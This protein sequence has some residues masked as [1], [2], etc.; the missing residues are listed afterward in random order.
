[1]HYADFLKEQGNL[2]TIITEEE[3]PF[4]R[5]FALRE[6]PILL[7]DLNQFFEDQEKQYEIQIEKFEKDILAWK[8][9][10]DHVRAKN[11]RP[12]DPSPRFDIINGANV[13]SVD[14]LSDRK[15]LFLTIETPDFRKEKALMEMKTFQVDNVLV[16]AGYRSHSSIDL[17]CFCNDEP[18]LYQLGLNESGETELL[19]QGIKK[20]EKI[21]KN[22]LT[23][24][25][26]V[27]EE[28]LDK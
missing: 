6:N 8:T 26:K 7:N 11:L 19:K 5:L 12:T 17:N 23:Y 28:N 9:L 14:R 3:R 20:A 27:E 21:V 2:L 15:G 10:E 18:G 25:S 13:T 4:E 22:M 24:F 1:M 16:C